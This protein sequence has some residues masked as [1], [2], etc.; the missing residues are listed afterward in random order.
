MTTVPF[1]NFILIVDK[2]L[3]QATYDTVNEG[4]A[5]NCTCSDCKNYTACKDIAFP[6]EVKSMLALL[7][8]DYRKECEVMRV[9]KGDD[10]LHNYFGSFH[11]QG[12]IKD[13][14]HS[15]PLAVGDHTGM[16]P[17]GKTFSIGFQMADIFT[18]FIDKE[19]LV[20]VEFE[21]K[22]PWVIDKGVET[23]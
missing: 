11:F 19:N 4:D 23:K 6:Q 1:K 18:F 20:Q 3:T 13:N 15:L 21:V 12:S 7:G 16:I 14:S 17:I 22:M 8:I 2:E 10:G 9:Q 5:E